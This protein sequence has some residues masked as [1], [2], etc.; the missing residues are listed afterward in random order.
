MRS[1][2]SIEFESEP[3]FNN[4]YKQHS[5]SSQEK[6]IISNEIS[7]RLSCNVIRKANFENSQYLSNIFV[8]PKKDGSHRLILN[9][10]CLNES[11]ENGNIEN[12][13]NIN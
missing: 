3:T 4:P 5:F 2:Y 8:V 12:S 6:S 9:L 1:G 13:N 7:K 10:R 11:V